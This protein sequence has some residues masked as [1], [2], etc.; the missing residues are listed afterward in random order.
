MLT[1]SAASLA[2]VPAKVTAIS[3]GEPYDPT[4]DLVEFSFTTP[5]VSLVGAQW[6]AGLWDGTD[7]LPGTDADYVAV[8]MVGPSGTAT[9]APGQYQVSVRITDSPEIPVLPAFLLKIN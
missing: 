7:P 2:Y 5:G 1:I 6:Y 3:R 4:N 9:L 8:C